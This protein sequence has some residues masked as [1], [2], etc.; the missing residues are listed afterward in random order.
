M[1]NADWN[2]NSGYHMSADQIKPILKGILAISLFL[3][4]WYLGESGFGDN[5]PEYSIIGENG[6]VKALSIPANEASSKSNYQRIIDAECTA[7][8]PCV[9]AFFVGLSEV[10]YPLSE[11]QAK[12]RTAQYNRHPSSGVDELVIAPR[13]TAK[14]AIANAISKANKAYWAA[15]DSEGRAIDPIALGSPKGFL[16]AAYEEALRVEAIAAERDISWWDAREATN[17]ATNG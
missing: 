14:Q 6:I 16:D 4:F 11:T 9:L 12:A 10:S 17:D 1:A 5:K 13:A 15:C 8:A 2:L 3:Y 7:D